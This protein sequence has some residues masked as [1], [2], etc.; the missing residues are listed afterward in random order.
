MYSAF[1]AC[2]L[3]SFF[4]LHNSACL[5]TLFAQVKQAKNITCRCG[6]QS[7]YEDLPTAQLNSR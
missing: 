1:K 7:R 4:R 3:I 5:K 6:E 2:K